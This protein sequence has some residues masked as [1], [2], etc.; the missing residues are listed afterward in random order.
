MELRKLQHVVALAEQ[1]SYVR[2]AETL[3]LTQSAL[4]RS[5][6][7]I[8]QECC[9]RLFDRSRSGTSP[10]AA[11]RQFVREAEDVIRRMR[12]LERNMHRLAGC[13][14]GEV[15]FGMAPVPGSVIL[16]DLL[17]T[18]VREHPKIRAHTKIGSPEQLLACVKEDQIEFAIVA[19]SLV[20]PVSDGFSLQPIGRVDV[21]AMVRPDHPLVGRLVSDT[22]LRNW[23][24]L[25]STPLNFPRNKIL[26]GFEPAVICDNYDVLR[27]V[28]LQTDGIWLTASRLGRGELVALEGL[29][30]TKPIQLVSVSLQDRTLSPLAR[31][32]IRL[33]TKVLAV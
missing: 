30:I 10:T 33:S 3:G 2:A 29:S 24:V 4:T 31:M 23:P 26:A 12:A 5:I 13:E 18:I 15:S 7:A 11:G 27:T 21:G 17:M 1:R 25:G 28:T 9:F 16:P 8:E 19:R 32:L 14:A 22:E 20:D 6:Q